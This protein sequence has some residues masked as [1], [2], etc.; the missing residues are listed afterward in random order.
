[1]MLFFQEQSNLPEIIILKYGL[2]LPRR[3]EGTLISLTSRPRAGFGSKD[4]FDNDCA[5]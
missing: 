4:D 3:M 5:L 2:F 1:M